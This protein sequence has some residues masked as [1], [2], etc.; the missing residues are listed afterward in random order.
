MALIHGLR[1]EINRLKK[2]LGEK[3]NI[4]NELR[5][6]VRDQERNMRDTIKKSVKHMEF[7]KSVEF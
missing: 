3:E 7:V 2:T 1:Q 5:T 4:I 6:T